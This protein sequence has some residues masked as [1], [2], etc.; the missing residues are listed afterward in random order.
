MRSNVLSWTEWI[1]IDEPPVFVWLQS[2]VITTAPSPTVVNILIIIV[3]MIE[4]P[5]TSDARGGSYDKVYNNPSFF[6]CGKLTLTEC[7]FNDDDKRDLDSAKATDTVRPYN[8]PLFEPS[9]K[10]TDTVRPNNN[11]LFDMFVDADACHADA[12][13]PADDVDAC[14]ADVANN[15]P[16]FEMFEMFVD[17][18]ACRPA[19]EVDAVVIP[20]SPSSPAPSSQLVSPVASMDS[21]TKYKPMWRSWFICGH[22]KDVYN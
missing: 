6:G 3:I 16:L 20:S 8:N 10:A 15:N 9:A 17:A 11:P 2:L 21:V 7:N 12:C 5:L 18:D 22:G 4:M 1:K 14:H 19:D 13:L